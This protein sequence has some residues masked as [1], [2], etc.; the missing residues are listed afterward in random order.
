MKISELSIIFN[1][2][3]GKT[4]SNNNQPQPPHIYANILKNDRV[5]VAFH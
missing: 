1:S 5:S 4:L 2:K 3:L